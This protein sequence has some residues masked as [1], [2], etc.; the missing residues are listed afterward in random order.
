MADLSLSW[1]ELHRL[2]PSLKVSLYQ[3][4]ISQVSNE[5]SDLNLKARW[6]NIGKETIITK[7]KL[8]C[9]QDIHVNLAGYEAVKQTSL[10]SIYEN[11]Y[12]R[13]ITQVRGTITATKALRNERVDRVVGFLAAEVDPL[14]V[15][16]WVTPEIMAS[17]VRQLLPADEALR[18]YEKKNPGLLDR[19]VTQI[20]GGVHVRLEYRFKS[21]VGAGETQEEAEILA[22]E[23]LADRLYDGD[24]PTVQQ[25]YPQQSRQLHKPTDLMITWAK[26]FDISDDLTARVLFFDAKNDSMDKL[27]ESIGKSLCRLYRYTYL[28]I[29]FHEK[30]DLTQDFLDKIAQNSAIKHAPYYAE[31]S[32][33]QAIDSNR[34]ICRLFYYLAPF[35]KEIDSHFEAILMSASASPSASAPVGVEPGADAAVSTPP[36]AADKTEMASHAEVD[37]VQPAKSTPA[38]TVT[39]VYSSKP[40]QP[41]TP[42]QPL[43]VAAFSGWSRFDDAQN[44][45]QWIDQYQVPYTAVVPQGKTRLQ[46]VSQFIS[47]EPNL[48][49]LIVLP[50]LDRTELQILAPLI[51]QVLAKSG[52]TVELLAG[53]LDQSVKDAEQVGGITAGVL[54]ALM[55][56]GVKFGDLNDDQSVGLIELNDQKLAFDLVLNAPLADDS[57]NNGLNVCQYTVSRSGTGPFKSVAASLRALQQP[58]LR[59]R[60]EKIMFDDELTDLGF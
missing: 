25:T 10:A 44:I 47:Q 11:L 49:L 29:K 39:S 41:S 59:S 53:N 22:E 46:V 48:A 26:M 45:R 56:R 60:L 27:I 3:I 21:A 12:H 42:K 34:I 13:L 20:G 19:K 18:L 7:L 43:K 31:S 6:S 37:N 57:V 35:G 54:L 1:D 9:L 14:V 2:K 51:S 8:Y 28:P 52:G 17:S 24:L 50:K 38:K 5:M 30:T 32:R 40:A 55:N 16:L 15:G 33:I 4:G 58:I 36:A 23:K